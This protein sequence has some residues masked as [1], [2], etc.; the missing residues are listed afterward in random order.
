MYWE[1]LNDL[2]TKDSKAAE[3]IAASVIVQKPASPQGK[4][5]LARATGGQ[6]LPITPS[7]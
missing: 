2:V 6:P 7:N 5:Y 1:N 3:H 4:I